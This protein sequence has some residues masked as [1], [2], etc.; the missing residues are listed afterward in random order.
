LRSTDSE[1]NT[2]YIFAVSAYNEA[3][4]EDGEKI[5]LTAN[6]KHANGRITLKKLKLVRGFQAK[7]N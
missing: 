2:T 6:T 3:E 5:L 4:G 1:P 7:K